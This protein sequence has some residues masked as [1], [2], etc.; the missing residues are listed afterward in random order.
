MIKSQ[1]CTRQRWCSAQN[2]VGWA[3]AQ[4]KTCKCCRASIVYYGSFACMY[5]ENVRKR[6][7]LE[8]LVLKYCKTKQ[9][10]STHEALKELAQGLGLGKKHEKEEREKERKKGGRE[11]ERPILF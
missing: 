3:C 7:D 2:I 10:L 4:N 5:F 6:Y 9:E 8:D 1:K 11:E